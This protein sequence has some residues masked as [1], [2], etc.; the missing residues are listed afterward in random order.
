MTIKAENRS[1]GNSF[2]KKLLLEV[3]YCLERECQQKDR[4]KAAC[5]VMGTEGIS[6]GVERHLVLA[7]IRHEADPEEAEDHHGPS[8][9]FGNGG[10]ERGRSKVVV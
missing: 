9:G 2:H 8:A 6:S 4:P 5:L 3:K 1:I 7:S 10:G